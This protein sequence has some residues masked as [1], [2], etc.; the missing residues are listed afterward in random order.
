MTRKVPL[1]P[2]ALV[3]LAVAVLIGLG[4]WQLQKAPQKEALLEQYR[5]AHRMPPIAYPTMPIA[6]ELPLYRYATAMCLRPI[7]KRAFA[8]RNRVGESGYVHVV[9]CATGAEGPGLSVQIGWSLDPNVKFNW[10]GG[11]VS[12]VIVPD[13]RTWMRLVAAT[14]AAGLAP[15][16]VPS[17]SLSVTPARHRQYA[18]TWFALAIAALAVYALALRQRWKKEQK[19]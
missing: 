16:A 2:T 5:A 3:A 9:D 8:G 1:I 6:G 19:T 7:S 14:P 18:M 10:N 13:D 17:P 15:N 12:G 11:P 4:V